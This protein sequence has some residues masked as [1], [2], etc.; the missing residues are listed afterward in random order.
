MSI[1]VKQ[2]EK[3]IQNQ[4]MPENMLDKVNLKFKKLVQLVKRIKRG[5]MV[6]EIYL[7]SKYLH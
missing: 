4:Y 2:N 7:S 5:N 3:Q 1:N 6:E